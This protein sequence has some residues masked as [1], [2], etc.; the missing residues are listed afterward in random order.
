MKQYYY[1]FSQREIINLYIYCRSEVKVS[2][3]V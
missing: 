2:E 3:T 1:R